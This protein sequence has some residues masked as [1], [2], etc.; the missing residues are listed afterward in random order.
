VLTETDRLFHF[1]FT[2]WR[3]PATRCTRP[4]W[5]GAALGRGRGRLPG[6]LRGPAG[7]KRL[8]VLADHGFT[9]LRAEV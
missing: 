4:A 1:L 8:L 3:S 6:P 7:P 2:A 5:P 9:R